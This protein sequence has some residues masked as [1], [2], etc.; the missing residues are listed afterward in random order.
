MAD[1]GLV[2]GAVFYNNKMMSQQGTD[3]RYTYTDFKEDSNGKPTGVFEPNFFVNLVTGYLKANNVDITGKVNATD[4]KFTGE[5]YAT[6]GTFN[7][8]GTEG[9]VSITKGSVRIEQYSD[10]YTNINHKSIT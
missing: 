7:A 5:I 10:L 3:S 8:I 1:F 6:N 9:M 4:G 2:G